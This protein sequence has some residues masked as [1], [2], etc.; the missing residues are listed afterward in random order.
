M[1]RA[2]GRTAITK[3]GEGWDFRIMAWQQAIAANQGSREWAAG[4]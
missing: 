4:V 3:S 2:E 1:E